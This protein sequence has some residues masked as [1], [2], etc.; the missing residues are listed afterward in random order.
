MSDKGRKKVLILR[1]HTFVTSSSSS[2]ARIKKKH[3]RYVDG[4]K[5]NISVLFHKTVHMLFSYF[6]SFLADYPTV[7]TGYT[8]P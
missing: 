2:K 3:I 5:P 8:I 1:I 7:V 6:H 4:S